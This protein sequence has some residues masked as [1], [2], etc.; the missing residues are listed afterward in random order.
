VHGV[1]ARGPEPGDRAGRTDGEIARIILLAAGVSAA[2]IDEHADAVREQACQAYARLAPG[3]LSE[4]VLPGVV[5]VLEWLSGEAGVVL[6]LLTGNF[7]PI[8]RLKLHRAGIGH[9]FPAG[10]GA[11]GS[12]SEDRAAL[13]GFARRR[14]GRPG[15]PHPRARTL[16][17]GDTPR[18]IACARAD[19]VHCVGVASGPFGVAELAGADAVASDASELPSVLRRIGLIGL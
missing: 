4:K 3:D 14:A 11:F 1:D 5:E 17:I 13:P 8:A 18:D 6:A 7:E 19:E 10:Q 9:Y 15:A 16:V 12:D 2:Q